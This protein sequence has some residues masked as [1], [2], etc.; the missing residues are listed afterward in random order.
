MIWERW[1]RVLMIEEKPEVR[2]TEQLRRTPVRPPSLASGPG[3]LRHA[4][5]PR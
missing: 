2:Q 5:L 3:D 4:G 1:E